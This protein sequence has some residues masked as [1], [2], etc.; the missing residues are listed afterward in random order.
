MTGGSI[1]FEKNTVICKNNYYAQTT[2]YRNTY[3]LL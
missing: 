2:I 3:Y 1:F